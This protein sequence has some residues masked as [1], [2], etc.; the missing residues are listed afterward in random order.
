MEWDEF[1]NELYAM[2]EIVSVQSSNL[3][4]DAA[5]VSKE[6]EESKIQALIDTPALDWQR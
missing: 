5:P 6:D 1:G 3:V 4:Q 2:P